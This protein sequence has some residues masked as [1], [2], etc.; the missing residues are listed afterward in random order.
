[1]APEAKMG[2]YCEYYFYNFIKKIP[3]E[4]QFF[5]EKILVRISKIS[6]TAFD[7]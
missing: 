2:Y 6:P 4:F 1:V 3:F 5:E 7:R